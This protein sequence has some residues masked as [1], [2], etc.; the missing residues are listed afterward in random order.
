[1]DKSQEQ[2]TGWQDAREFEKPFIDCEILANIYMLFDKLSHTSSEEM[3][4]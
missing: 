4:I 1:M 2:L 3:R